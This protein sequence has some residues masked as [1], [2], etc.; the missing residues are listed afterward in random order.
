MSGNRRSFLLLPGF[1][2]VMKSNAF[3]CAAFVLMLSTASLIAA[4]AEQLQFKDSMTNEYVRVSRLTLPGHHSFT[5]AANRHLRILISDQARSVSIMLPGK[6]VASSANL[7]TLV[8]DNPYRIYNHDDAQVSLIMLEMTASP[9]RIVCSNGDACPWSIRSLDPVPVF[10]SDHLTIF[11]IP[12]PWKPEPHSIMV[13]SV[14]VLLQDV[15]YE[16]WHAVWLETPQEVRPVHPQPKWSSSISGLA[17][18]EPLPYLLEIAFY[19][20]PFCFCKRVRGS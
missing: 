10:L 15:H 17:V 20:R 8:E 18:A 9:G 7:W 6:P 4:R 19:D 13:P 16:A 2:G 11:K 1:N 12:L 5:L 3:R 14:D